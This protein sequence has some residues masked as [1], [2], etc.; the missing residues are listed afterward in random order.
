MEKQKGWM[1]T[2]AFAAFC[3]TTKETLRHYKDIGLLSP[4]YQGDN[5]YFYYDVQQFYDYYAISIFRLT[6][7]PLE[8]IRRCLLSQDVA[9]T[10]TQLRAQ[11]HS[12][13]QERHRLE[14]MEFVLSSTIRNWEFGSVSDLT[15]AVAYF[16]TEHLLTLPADE[17]ERQIS[18]DADEDEMLI[19]V[20]EQCTQLCRQYGLQSDY[21]LGAIHVPSSMGE[22]AEI[23]HLYTRIREKADCPYYL[24]KPA[25][26]YLYL[27]CRGRWDIS[28]G[29]EL[30]ARHIQ[31]QGLRTVGSLYA[32]DL[33]G[34]ILNGAEKNSMSMLSIQLA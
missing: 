29:Y 21:Q 33:A 8:E 34:F 15:P 26:T 4:A 16:E 24:E 6:G 31:Q 17:L 2:G 22:A 10:L 18:P 3:G 30:L 19:T 1:T 7:T 27:C 13:E 23:S 25:G 9:S 12:L 32:C 14:Q 28:A 5:G 11:K 20:L